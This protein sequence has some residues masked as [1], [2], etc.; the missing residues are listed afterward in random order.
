MT[1][2]L[3]SNLPQFSALPQISSFH[4]KKVA[5]DQTRIPILPTFSA[6]HS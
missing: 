1:T 6:V 4:V 5:A 3:H 2:T